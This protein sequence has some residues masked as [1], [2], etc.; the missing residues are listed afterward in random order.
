M[1]FF[2]VSFGIQVHDAFERF[3]CDWKPWYG[4]FT[5]FSALNNILFCMKE[6][7]SAL[8]LA[9]IILSMH[10]I[11]SAASAPFNA[12]YQSPVLPPFRKV[13]RRHC[14]FG[15]LLP[16]KRTR[17]LP[18]PDS[19][20]APLLSRLPSDITSWQPRITRAVTVFLA[21]LWL[22]CPVFSAFSGA[23]AVLP[24][25]TSPEMIICCLISQCFIW[26]PSQKS[27]GKHRDPINEAIK[28]SSDWD[29]STNLPYLFSKLSPGPCPGFHQTW[30]LRAQSIPWPLQRMS[31]CR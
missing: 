26:W 15:R 18:L 7:F 24:P 2:D 20:S 6:S 30:Q 19:D 16:A 25:V 23:S 27:L 14:H 1:F 8:E 10:Y 4:I 5:P 12:I 11:S 17:A 13:M 9:F 29:H 28:Q 3:F 22:C 31:S 21:L